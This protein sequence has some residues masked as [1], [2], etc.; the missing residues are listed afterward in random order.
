[1]NL[2]VFSEQ[3]IENLRHEVARLEQEG[4]EQRNNFE[5]E[6]SI[7]SA[8]EAKL[9]DDINNL[10]E[11]LI[12]KSND[13]SK[14]ETKLSESNSQIESLSQLNSELNSQLL[15]LH[16]KLASSE[17]RLSEAVSTQQEYS[18]QWTER[19][20]ARFNIIQINKKSMNE[21]FLK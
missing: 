11:Q 18:R 10:Q 1:M 16:Q 21:T 13:L 2:S 15:E 7:F 20:Q 5:S 14:I 12:N 4:N 3:V 9:R 8:T 17:E 6:V 19:L